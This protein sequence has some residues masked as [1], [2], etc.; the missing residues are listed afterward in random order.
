MTKVLRMTD[1]NGKCMLCL[2]CCFGGWRENTRGCVTAVAVAV[3]CCLLLAWVAVAVAR[4]LVVF[5]CVES[6]DFVC[7]MSS[8]LCTTFFTQT[9]IC[10]P[11]FTTHTF[12]KRENF[13]NAHFQPL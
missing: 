11:S 13:L 5:V 12:P 10:K 6:D 1:N 9:G 7:V 8:A 2:L 3:M 4:L